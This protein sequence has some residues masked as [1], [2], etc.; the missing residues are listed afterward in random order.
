MTF[1]LWTLIDNDDGPSLYRD[2]HDRVWI[3]PMGPTIGDGNEYYMDVS[4]RMKVHESPVFMDKQENLKKDSK[5]AGKCKK[6]GTPLNEKQVKTGRKY[7]SRTCSNK[8]K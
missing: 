7:C 2:Q 1:Q 5:A 8:D 3:G 6:C 4:S